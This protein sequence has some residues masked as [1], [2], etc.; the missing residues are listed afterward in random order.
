MRYLFIGIITLISST[1][2]SQKTLNAVLLK[3]GSKDSL[4][5]EIIVRTNLF[6]KTLLD[7][8]SIYKTV[9]VVNKNDENWLKEDW[10]KAKEIDYLEFIDFRNKK[11]IFVSQNYATELKKMK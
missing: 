6:D 2:Y 5:V 4:K 11:R 9:K 3:K 7:E 8:L 10:L 1:I